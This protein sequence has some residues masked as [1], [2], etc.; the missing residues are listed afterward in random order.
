MTRLY[1]ERAKLP[2]PSGLN[3]W[4]DWNTDVATPRVA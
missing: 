3:R 2:V 1:L 4:L